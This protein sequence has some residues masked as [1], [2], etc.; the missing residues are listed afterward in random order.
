[1][2]KNEFLEELRKRLNILNTEEKEDIINEYRDTIEEKVKNGKSEEEAVTDFGNI[3]D[4]V[5]EI[6]S[7]YKINPDYD[8]GT[9]ASKSFNDAIKTGA[10]KLASFTDNVVNNIKVNEEK[11]TL[12][13]VFEII[14]KVII[15]LL[16]LCI[17]KW[18]FDI[19]SSL[20]CNIF[21]FGSVTDSVFYH[22]I[23]FTFNILYLAVCIVI[24]VVLAK[25]YTDK[26]TYKEEKIKEYMDKKQEKQTTNE[27]ETK[28][29][30]YRDTEKVVEKEESLIIK[31]LKVFAIICFMIP[32]V[33]AIIG[34]S[35][36][37][38]VLI[39]LTIKCLIFLGPLL[40][41]IGTLILFSFIFDALNNIIFRNKKICF[42]S[43][44]VSIVF[45][46]IGAF[47]SFES[48]M[49]I[50]F[51]NE[52]PKNDFEIET[53]VETK[54]VTD[55]FVYK[56]KY[57]TVDISIDNTIEDNK[58]VIETSYYKEL[59]E[60][61]DNINLNINENHHDSYYASTIVLNNEIKALYKLVIKN[62]KHGEIY[63]YR[64]LFEP[65]VL[66]K[67]NEN[68]KGKVVIIEKD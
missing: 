55:N 60:L 12:E 18:P 44:I 56:D 24:I 21:E 61:R 36:A 17:L 39:V 4:L 8:K 13:R 64:K 63:N 37:V 26:V 46:G 35:I 43:L 65:S 25:R 14:I 30:E 29:K 6:L 15:L 54:D 11:I 22:M 28:K 27:T 53:K 52:I 31:I 50:E 67:V 2:N 23:K 19:I 5:K 20:V 7:A 1:M 57:D 3:D 66:I 32:L 68:T 45:I 59:V 49:D 62:L 48:F 16:I 33:F 34:L 47:L 58:I 51:I 41:V 42:A 10:S 40:T 38:V 9:S